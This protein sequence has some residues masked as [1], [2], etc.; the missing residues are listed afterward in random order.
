MIDKQ[1]YCQCFFLLFDSIRFFF[2]WSVHMCIWIGIE[3][4][5]NE[6]KERNISLWW[7]FF[8]CL[9]LLLL[10]VLIFS[11]VITGALLQH[12]HGLKGIKGLLRKCVFY[13]QCE[14][15]YFFFFVIITFWKARN[16]YFFSSTFFFLLLLLLW[17]IFYQTL[18]WRFFLFIGGLS[19]A[20]STSVSFFI[21]HTLH[22]QWWKNHSDSA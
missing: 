22:L 11:T 17:E 18:K 13:I 6:M 7:Q 21:P 20:F 2:F 4:K 12:V 3:K 15:F 1:N 8:L 14:Q 16:R 10:C 19:I 9:V 5:M